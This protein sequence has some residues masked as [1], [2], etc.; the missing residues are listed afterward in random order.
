MEYITEPAPCPYGYPEPKA[1]PIANVR[2]SIPIQDERQIPSVDQVIAMMLDPN[3]I[4]QTI[5]DQGIVGIFEWVPKDVATGLLREIET[6]LSSATMFIEISSDG[7]T[8]TATRLVDVPKPTP[9]ARAS[10]M[11]S[12]PDGDT[13]IILP[14]E[15]C[16][17]VRAILGL[18]KDQTVTSALLVVATIQLYDRI[19]KL[20]LRA[21]AR[22]LFGG[23]TPDE[24]MDSERARRELKECEHLMSILARETGR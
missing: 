10:P 8:L 12:T 22:T 23:P 19:S 16:R 6:R 14:A 20:R 18:R 24:Q 2:A 1:K 5:T 9:V 3:E 11:Q 21:D 17:I 13:M 15:V 4:S 7:H